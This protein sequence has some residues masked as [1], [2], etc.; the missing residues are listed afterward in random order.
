MRVSK[1]TVVTFEYALK[2]PTGETLDSSEGNGPLT[3]VHGTSSILGGL[4]AALEGRE[5]GEHFTVSIPPARAYGLRDEKLLRI[6]PRTE[7]PA[8]SELRVGQ[9]FRADTDAGTRLATV[10]WIDGDDVTLDFN[11]PLAGVTLHFDITVMS[12]R[13][14]TPD[15]IASGSPA[16]ATDNDL[17]A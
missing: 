9:Q 17:P 7:F 14:A 3:Y 1:H 5:A 4:E 10:V 11:H 16:P 8:V 2:G 13:P 12:L 15:E 6:L